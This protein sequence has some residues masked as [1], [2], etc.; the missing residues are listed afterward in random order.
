MRDAQEMARG[1]HI[2][3]DRDGLRLI[4]MDLPGL[5]WKKCIETVGNIC[6]GLGTRCLGGKPVSLDI[7]FDKER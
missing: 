6:E 1:L 4:E 3:E 5:L 7:G 2:E